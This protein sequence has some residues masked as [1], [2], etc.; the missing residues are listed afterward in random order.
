MRTRTSLAAVCTLSVLAAAA[1]AQCTTQWLPGWG[2]PV[3]TGPT[4]PAVRVLQA[5]DPDGPGPLGAHM[6]AAG[7]FLNIEG[8]PINGIAVWNGV[9]WTA[10]API[11]GTGAATVTAVAQFNGQ[12]Y[13]GANFFNTPGVTNIARYNGTQWQALGAGVSGEVRALAVYNGALIVGGA[14]TSAGG[15]VGTRAIARWNGTS[16]SALGGDIDPPTGGAAAVNAL[17][18]HDGRLFVGGDFA[19]VSGVASAD[20]AVWT[21]A[22]WEAI[23]GTAEGTNTVVNS[24]TLHNGAVYAGGRLMTPSSELRAAARYDNG[25]WDIVPGTITGNSLVRAIA[26]YDGRLVATGHF[27]AIVGSPTP[28]SA[29]AWDGSQWTSLADTVD[30]LRVSIGPGG[31]HCSVVYDG[32]LVMGG[33]IGFEGVTANNCLLTWDGTRWGTFAKGFDAIPVAMLRDED[34]SIIFTGGFRVAGGRR[35]NGVVRWDG[36]AFQPIGS[37]IVHP[38]STNTADGGFDL[39]RHNGEIYVAGQCSAPSLNSGVAKWNGSAWVRPAT[40]ANPSGQ[41]YALQSFGDALIV[42]GNGTSSAGIGALRLSG[43][44]WSGTG[45]PF[46]TGPQDLTIFQDTLYGSTGSLRRWD[47]LSAWT[48]VQGP[49][50]GVVRLMSHGD[51]LY[52][53]STGAP[54]NPPSCVQ[55]FD[56][57]GFESVGAGL[58]EVL[59]V[60]SLSGDIIARNGDIMVTRKFVIQ[61]TPTVQ[62]HMARFNG[63]RW[64]SVPGAIDGPLPTEPISSLVRGTRFLDADGVLWVSGAFNNAGGKPSPYLARYVTSS[65]PQVTQH[66]E[67]VDGCAGASALFV[68]NVADAT[69]VEFR[70]RRN[71]QVLNDGPQSG[72]GTV[73]GASTPTLMLAGLVPGNAGQYDCVATTNCGTSFTAAAALT[74]VDACC[75]SIDF[76]NDGLFPDNLDLQDFLSVFGHGPCTNDPNCGDIDF[77]NDGLYPDNEDILAIFRVFGGGHCH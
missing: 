8:W 5:F 64:Q 36:S 77:N 15:L 56:G 6:L 59:S 33:G 71:G 1:S 4:S 7:A 69:G 20:A 66:P 67:P 9:E 22:G 28:T 63:V 12:Y 35:V 75:D 24:F 52:L 70:W 18:V 25:A 46:A 53:L 2:T 42:G 32:K 30:P 38:Q 31:H 48:S 16:W 3:I 34:G 17:F 10:P 60:N 40:A 23:T 19:G 57:T 51:H 73:S 62:T 44:T 54:G 68:M 27:V 49:F 39:A 26:S 29:I 11:P 37:G 43:G 47:G 76:N 74:V 50:F 58:T 45:F 65:P 14:F 72:G 41:M 61:G 55:R 13:A 21:T